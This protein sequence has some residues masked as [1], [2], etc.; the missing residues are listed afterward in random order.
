MEHHGTCKKRGMVYR[1]PRSSRF[2]ALAE[3]MSHQTTARKST[4]GERILWT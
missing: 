3:V 4:P 2:D 1:G